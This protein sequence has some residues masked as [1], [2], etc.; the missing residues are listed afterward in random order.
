MKRL[1]APWRSK[2]V[3]QK[4]KKG[5]IFCIGKGAS[6]ERRKHVIKE[7]DFSFAILNIFPYNNGHVMVAPGRHVKDISAL[8]DDELFDLMKL[9]RDIQILLQRKM[10][11]RGFNIGINTG[12]AGGA[13]VKG[14]LH[15]HVVPRWEGDTNFMPVVSDTKVIPESLEDLK[16]TLLS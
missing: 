11:P 13:G 15:V 16:K 3:K 10:N 4:R 5:C 1:W 8:R 14:H 2:F 9:V 7:S 12:T 6:P